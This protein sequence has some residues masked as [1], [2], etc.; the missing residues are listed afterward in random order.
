MKVVEGQLKFLEMVSDLS[1]L[2]H[3]VASQSLR[4]FIAMQQEQQA[5]TPDV[6][7]SRIDVKTTIEAET[8]KVINYK[9]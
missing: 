9:S 8:G 2:S 1:S 5:F 6:L 7:P 3:S 4:E